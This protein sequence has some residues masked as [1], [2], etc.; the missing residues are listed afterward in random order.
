MH[1]P[2][3]LVELCAA[4]RPRWE[5]TAPTPHA[6]CALGFAA[7]LAESRL[8]FPQG[9]HCEPPAADFASSRGQLPTSP[10]K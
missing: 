5:P 7:G 8:P 9:T 10:N 6:C 4:N 2:S 3:L 1:A